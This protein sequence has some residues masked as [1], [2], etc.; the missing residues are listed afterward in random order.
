MLHPEIRSYEEMEAAVYATYDYFIN[1]YLLHRYKGKTT[2]EVR[3]AALE[4]DIPE[5]YSIPKNNMIIR[6]WDHIH[7]L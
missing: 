6:Y 7:S 1:E 3:K 4:T 5:Q 2:G